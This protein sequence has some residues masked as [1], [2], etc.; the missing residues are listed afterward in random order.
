MDFVESMPLSAGYSVIMVVVDRLSKYAHFV[1]LKHP[2]T[3]LSVAQAFVREI[4]RLHGVPKSIVSDRDRVFLSSVWKNLFQLQGTKLCMSSR[5]HLQS[6]GQTEVVNRILEQ[7]L[8]CFASDQPK[9][10]VEWIPWAEYSYNSTPHSA[11]KLTPFEAVYG[12]PP[13]T[14]LYYI[15]GTTK[16][17]AVDS[18]LQDRDELLRFLKRNLQLAQNRMKMQA[19]QHRCELEF[20]VGDWVYLK[21]Q[22]YRQKTVAHRL[23]LKLAPKFQGPFRV[24]ARTGTVA[25][26]LELPLG[27]Q[28]H[29]VFHVSLLKRH[30]GPEPSL[31]IQD[32]IIDIPVEVSNP[33]EA[34]LAGRVVHKGKYRPKEQSLV[35]WKDCPSEE[36]IWEN[37]WRF[38]KS[39]PQFILADKND[40]GL[41]D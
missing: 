18:F 35:K 3:A 1:P 36:A 32:P 13:T 41:M 19:D 27:S 11:T 26:R 15:L 14:L 28:I 23:F 6:D 24:M 40:L 33:P 17:A 5:Y 22:P 38:A 7:Y 2:Y 20:S 10:W 16:V 39:F 12:L 30:F 4:F 31:P 29:N 8:R 37:K 21:L 34:F 25:Y 9:K